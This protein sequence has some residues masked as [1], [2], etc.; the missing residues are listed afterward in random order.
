MFVPI[1]G[2]CH[3]KAQFI[4]RPPLLSRSCPN[5]VSLTRPRRRSRLA[6]A[7]CTGDVELQ[8]KLGRNDPCPCG[9]GKR[10]KRCC[11]KS[12]KYDGSSRDHYFP[13][14]PVSRRFTYPQAQRQSSG[15]QGRR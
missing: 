14:A 13:G 6:T 3:G 7:R 10:Y 8:E 15:I 2:G 5:G 11:L 9:S 4:R 12:G 1:N